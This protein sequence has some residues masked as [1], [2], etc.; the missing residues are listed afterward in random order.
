[1][2]SR[3]QTCRKE[4]GILTPASPDRLPPIGELIADEPFWR[5][6]V[7]AAGEGVAHLRVWRT[8]EPEPGHLAVVTQ[9][10]S[11][12]DVT[13]SVRQ[14][15]AE[16]ARRYGPSLLLLEHQL[17]PAAGE[18]AETVNLVRIG[19]DGSPHW[20][21]VWPSP[22]DNP[23]HAGLEL[24]MAVHGRQIVSKPASWFDSCEDQEG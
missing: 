6:P 10:G 14:I 17:A 22:Q 24:W 1:M 21:R 8:A 12:A 23:S 5:Y 18:G 19:A 9:T 2:G 7:G 13:Q 11:G 4:P 20:L 15:W 3:L 16:L